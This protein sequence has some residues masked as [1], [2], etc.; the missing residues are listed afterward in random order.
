MFSGRFMEGHDLS[1][2]TPREIELGDDPGSLIVILNILHMRNDLVPME[3]G[4]DKLLEI[5]ITA[6][7][8]DC[9]S[10][11]QFASRTWLDIACEWQ[12]KRY[13]GEGG[14]YVADDRGF[15]TEGC[16]N[17]TEPYES[18]REGKVMT[19][20]YLFRQVSCFRK[21]TRGL[22]VEWPCEFYDDVFV[23]EEISSLLPTNL[24][25]KSLLIETPRRTP[26]GQ[27]F[28]P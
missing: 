11:C 7:K 4:V 24:H 23:T 21:I 28:V 19:A 26:N 2:A 22:V 17:P 18:R 3:L 14:D 5:A 10:S 12:A 27:Y 15:F 13:D 1:S 9:T 25:S 8:Y 20:A 6:D 16:D